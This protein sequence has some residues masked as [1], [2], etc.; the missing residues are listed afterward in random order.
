MSRNRRRVSR[1]PPGAGYRTRRRSRRDCVLEIVPI[2]PEAVVAGA[3]IAGCAAAVSLAYRGTRTLLLDPN[4]D[5]PRR[6]AGEWLHPPGV[7]ELERLGVDFSKIPHARGKGFA[8]FFPGDPAPIVLPYPQG[9]ESLSFEHSRLLA[10][11]RERV[12]EVPG[13]EFS[14]GGKF[15]GVQGSVT[16]YKLADSDEIRCSRGALV[17]GSD[18]KASAVRRIFDPGS[19]SRVVSHMAG[20]LVD[21][22]ELTIEGFAHVLIGAPGPVLVYRIGERKVRVCFDVP[23]SLL[24]SC[25]SGSGLWS[26]YGAVFPQS[27]RASV[28]RALEGRRVQWAANRIRNRDWYGQDSVAL[29]GDAAGHTHPLSACGMTLALLDA[30]CLGRVA[31]VSE[32]VRERQAR[33]RV[34]EIVSHVLYRVMS[35][36]DPGS[37]TL[38]HGLRRLWRTDPV[39]AGRAMRLLT[40]EETG[41]AAFSRIFLGGVSAALN[42]LGRSSARQSIGST[43]ADFAGLVAFARWLIGDLAMRPASSSLGHGPVA[44][45]TA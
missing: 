13:I 1:L 5:Q 24:S 32:Y 17:V 18:G 11:M 35:D 4:P 30:E 6:F 15:C 45:A 16:R 38:R 23:S 34:P 26:A 31:T 44:R 8:I 40:T 27:M 25:R 19:E 28:Q 9:E 29:V 2:P 39:L 33:T 36:D 20:L 42:E 37:V 7:R 43:A 10:L 41:L 21:D 3:G 14:P 12:D 22:L